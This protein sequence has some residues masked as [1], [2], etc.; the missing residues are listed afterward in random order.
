MVCQCEKDILQ[1][2]MGYHWHAMTSQVS[3]GMDVEITMKF[4]EHA[5]LLPVRAQ[6]LVVLAAC[7]QSLRASDK[8]TLTRSEPLHS[9]R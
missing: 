5:S 8:Q 3:E 2:P 4:N 1:S 9:Y 7:Y 6:S